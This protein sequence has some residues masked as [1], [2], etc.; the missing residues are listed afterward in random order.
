MDGFKGSLLLAV[1]YRDIFDEV[2]HE[3]GTKGAKKNS[4]TTL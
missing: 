1:E 2:M 3:S 4:S